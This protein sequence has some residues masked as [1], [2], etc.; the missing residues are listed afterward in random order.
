MKE[1]LLAVILCLVLLAMPLSAL[2][3]G[4][5]IYILTP[6]EDHGWTGSVATFAKTSAEEIN[7]AGTW[8]A[9]VSTAPDAAS[10]ITQLEDIVANHAKDA[11]GVVIL[12]GVTIGKNSVIGAGSIVTRDIPENVVAVG[13]PCRV[14]RPIGEKDRETFFRDEKIDWEEING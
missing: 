11:A 3:E 8:K 13:N 5:T 12:P 7:A 14:M 9:E 4:D 2:A 1:T 10:Q 6:T